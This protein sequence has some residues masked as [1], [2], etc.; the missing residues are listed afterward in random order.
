MKI[1][2]V[3]DKETKSKFLDLVELIYKDDEAFVRPLDVQIEEIFNPATN[4]FFTHGEAE[5]FI[6]V[7]DDGVTIGR[8]AAFIN[9]KKAYGFEQP[10]GGMGFF[11]CI[12]DKKA[13]FLL[14][15]T[16]KDWLTQRGM[17]AM[18]GPINF[19]ENDNFWGLLVEGFTQ[20]GFGMQYN[21]PYYVEFYESY[22][23]KNYFEQVTNHLNPQKPFPERFW[24]IAG[25]VVSRENYD[26]RTFNWK[27]S[28]KFISDFKEV[29]DDAWKFHENFTPMQPEVLR[30][31]LNEA[32]SF[33]DKDMIWYVYHNNEP[34]AFL[35]MFPDVNQILKHFNG[36]F[37][38]FNKL[39][40]LY[41]KRTIE[42]TRSRVVILGVKTQ[43]QRLGIESGIFWHL[44][45]VMAKRPHITEMELSWVG[46]F[47]P[48]MTALH[49]AMGADFGKK[50][51]TYR[52]IF[53]PKKRAETHRAGSIPT[54]TKFQTKASEM[55]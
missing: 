34:I 10:T 12:N 50:H 28:E 23:F 32:K 21:P 37:T 39:R 16:A 15:D 30:N 8:V 31:S 49:N 1:L 35:I 47:N 17:E 45:D 36:K 41:Y 43:Y 18:D 3:I 11:E 13:A 44:R 5:R 24:K 42:M 25:R 52:Y 9:S 20:P 54:G 4:N 38:L 6:L 26:F 51:I 22:G 46:D 33:M 48:K 7:N 2:P 53:D 14:F 19:G 55:Q 40:F 29:Y 27:E